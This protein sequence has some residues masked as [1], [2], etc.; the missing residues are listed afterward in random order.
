MVKLGKVESKEAQ[1]SIERSFPLMLAPGPW[2]GLCAGY[3]T[4]G[5]VPGRVSHLPE[6]ALKSRSRHPKFSEMTN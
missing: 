6:N 1:V 4:G 2:S 5:G 3:N